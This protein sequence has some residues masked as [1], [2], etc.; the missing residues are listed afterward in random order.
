MGVERDVD[1]LAS[2]T[3]LRSFAEDLVAFVFH[4]L[5]SGIVHWCEGKDHRTSHVALVRRH[6]EAVKTEWETVFDF[7]QYDTLGKILVWIVMGYNLI[8]SVPCND[9]RVSD[10]VG[11]LV[12]KFQSAAY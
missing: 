4:D 1:L 6:V 10:G 7:S 9:L 3:L 8:C 2:F 5:D 12:L 11:D